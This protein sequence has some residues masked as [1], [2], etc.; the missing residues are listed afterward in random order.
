MTKMPFLEEHSSIVQSLKPR[1]SYGVSGRSDFGAYQSLATYSAN[2][3][4][5]IDGTWVTG[6]RPSNNANP[7]LGWEK[8]TA[9]NVGVDFM[10]WNR[11]HGSIEYFDRQSR[12][13]LYNYTA[14]QPPYVY[15][16]ILVNVGTTKNT[17]IEVALNGEVIVDQPVTWSTGINYAYGTTKVTKLSNSIYKAS[18]LDLYQK[19]GVGTSEYFFRYEEGSKVGEFYGYKYAG[20]DDAHNMLVYNK[21]GEK[22]PAASA[23]PEDKVYIGNGEPKHFLT[24]NNTVRYKSWDLSVMF[25][26][27]F[28]FQ[29]FNM[30]KYGMGLQGSGSDNVFRSA[31]LADKDVWTGG[32][33]ISSYFLE[34]GD[35]FK[36]QNV[37][38][39]YS[40]P[41]HNNRLIDSL[42]IYLSAKNLFTLTKYTGNDPS[43]VTSTGITPGVDT[44]SAYPSAAQVTLGVTFRFR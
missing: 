43:I 36:L 18:Y 25:Q 34:N 41:F 14:P 5:L 22:I 16:N 20:Y 21:D 23:N 9:L 1:I 33:V 40:F 10:L 30:R 17:G 19:P 42:R 12:D 31:Y 13:L 8:A 15:S 29:I 37:T 39:G 28:G 32:G 27:A 26:G 2:G 38:L 7:V 6:Y 35:Y 24:W 4:Y 3:N 44:N 11:L